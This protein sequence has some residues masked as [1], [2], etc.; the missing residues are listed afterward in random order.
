MDGSRKEKIYCLYR[1]SNAGPSSSLRVAMPP[2]VDA[3]EYRTCI[4]QL[5]HS[6]Y[7]PRNSCNLSK[8]SYK[9][10]SRVPSTIFA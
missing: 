5:R 8:N 4:F 7:P 3:T 9:N 2:T 10:C 6:L 1:D